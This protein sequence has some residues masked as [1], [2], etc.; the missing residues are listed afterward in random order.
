MRADNLGAIIFGDSYRTG[1]IL[2]VFGT[3]YLDSRYSIIVDTKWYGDT[4]PPLFVSFLSNI[5]Q[6]TPSTR[7][8]F[9]FSESYLSECIDVLWFSDWHIFITM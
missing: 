5:S 1:R 7:Q 2:V 6:N 4:V 3:E 9:L 8:T